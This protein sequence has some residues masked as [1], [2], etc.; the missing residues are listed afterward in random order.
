MDFL[1]VLPIAFFRRCEDVWPGTWLKEATWTFAILET[2]HTMVL[3][4]LL[5]AFQ[6]L[7]FGCSASA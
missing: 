7:N 5:G 4:V 3:A 2:I 6:L 1:H